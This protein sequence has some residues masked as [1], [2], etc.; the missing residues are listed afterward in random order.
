MG[1]TA[2]LALRY[3]AATDRVADGALAMQHLAEDVDTPLGLQ[4]N[5]PRCRLYHAASP[6]LANGVATSIAWDTEETDASGMHDP[7]VNPSRIT[8]VTAGYYDVRAQGI[9]AANA[10]G[11]RTLAIL[12]NGAVVA[13]TRHQ[14]SPATASHF[15]QV[16]DEV[17]LGVGDY[18]EIQATQGSGA[19]LA[20]QGGSASTF[21]RVTRRSA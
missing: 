4:V 6:N 8:A 1:T 17:Y 10:T 15:A 9:F 16:T 14:A 3:P 7:A 19:A 11:Y 12:K 13:A 5:P 21:V 18:I 20:L 2:K